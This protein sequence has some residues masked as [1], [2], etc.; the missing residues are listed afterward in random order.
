MALLNADSDADRP[1]LVWAGQWPVI[2]AS[3]WPGLRSKST[4]YLET[5]D[6]L[7][8][9]KFPFLT[10]ASPVRSHSCPGWSLIPV[11]LGVANCV[12]R[13]EKALQTLSVG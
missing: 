5:Q 4:D 1:T 11:P 7:L 2:V 8:E 6:N 12:L 3:G 13:V 9:A 10:L